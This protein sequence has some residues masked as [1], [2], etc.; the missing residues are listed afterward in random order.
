MLGQDLGQ[1]AHEEKDY[2]KEE[3][4]LGKQTDQDSELR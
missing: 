3:V 1:D 4:N 2:R